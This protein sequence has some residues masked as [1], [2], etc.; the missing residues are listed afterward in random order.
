MLQAF[1]HVG[2]GGEQR[3][4]DAEDHACQDTER[5]GEDENARIE[6]NVV[7]PGQSGGCQGEEEIESPAREKHAGGATRQPEQDTFGEQLPNEPGAA[8]AERSANGEFAMSRGGAGEEQI[9][10]VGA[11]NE[12]DAA[13]GAKQRV[14]DGAH[15]AHRIVEDRRH[16]DAPAFVRVGVLAGELG[17]E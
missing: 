9:G 7:R 14:E 3:R 2:V 1:L 10:D 15:I 11:G 5:E 4:R 13:D 17:G 6:M 8:R 16:G 12:Q